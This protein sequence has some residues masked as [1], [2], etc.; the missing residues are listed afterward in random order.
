M[1]HVP[2][3]A[4]T[5][6]SPPTLDAPDPSTTRALQQTPRRKRA[7]TSEEQYQAALA[8]A[9]REHVLPIRVGTGCYITASS[10][11]KHAG[12]CYKQYVDKD[13][14][15]TCTCEAGEW[16]GL[17]KHKARVMEMERQPLALPTTPYVDVQEE[18][19]IRPPTTSEELAD[20]ARQVYHHL[21][22]HRRAAGHEALR[23]IDDPLATDDLSDALRR[24]VD[25]L[26]HTLLTSMSLTTGNRMPKR[27]AEPLVHVIAALALAHKRLAALGA[28]STAEAGSL[29]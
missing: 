22:T 14:Q 3:T 10:N 2:S 11:P 17:C 12:Q 23:D 19:A 13:G 5:L 8:R 1:Q 15:V 24:G 18:A 4:A 16:G 9:R 21:D 6:L 20:F 27:S 26:T 25:T 28:N 29:S 7:R